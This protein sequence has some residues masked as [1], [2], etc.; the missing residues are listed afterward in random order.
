[1]VKKNYFSGVLGA[2]AFTLI[3]LLVVVLIIGILAAVALPQYQKAVD[4]SRATELLVQG[5][6]ILA[7]QHRHY[8]ATNQWTS[9][10]EILDLDLPKTWSCTQGQCQSS[11][12]SG[13]QI[14]F[15][16]STYFGS[17][18]PS[19]WCLVVTNN[20][21]GKKLCESFGGK[22]YHTSAQDVDYYL[23]RALF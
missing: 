16:I 13:A 21:R 2:E 22:Y 5:Q 9:D 8:L 17:A 6:A 19:M 12:M 3:E 11:T 7:A 1:M 18:N 23:I 10:A 20:S 4:K 14:R 15:E